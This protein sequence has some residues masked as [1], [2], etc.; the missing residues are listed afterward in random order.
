MVARHVGLKSEHSGDNGRIIGGVL[1][2]DLRL[3]LVGNS[4]AARWQEHARCWYTFQNARSAL[5][6]L[7]RSR[8]PKAVWLPAFICCELAA[9]VS[10]VVSHLRYFPVT[11][12]LS[13]D[14]KCLAANLATGDLVLAVDY[15]GRPPSADFR[16]FVGRRP[17]VLWVED[18]CQAL[19]PGSEPWGHWLLYS[20]RKLFG[21]PDG[22]I[23]VGVR[24]TVA[25]PTHID[26]DPYL[27]ELFWPVLWR[28]EDEDN[29]QAWYPAYRQAESRMSV[30]TRPMSRLSAAIL[31]SL[32]ADEIAARRR[33]NF[34]RLAESL[35]DLG[36]FADTK[37]SWVPLGF[38]IRVPERDRVVQHLAS[39][40][41]FCA[42]HWAELP[43]DPD[44]FRFEHQLA[45]QILTLPCDHRYGSAD[46]DRLVRAVR[47]ALA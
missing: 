5:A 14:V 10:S 26:D 25:P 40:R 7:I 38:P 15:F 39:A 32:D 23:L 4:V 8:S 35:S 42:R 24:D 37:L 12:D 1:P 11:D 41:M 30:T 44:R 2:L 13:P 34:A 18:R 27:V 47:A 16:A 21:V 31:S 20:P 29:N 46:M 22:G 43:S 45:R 33:Q 3:A 6:H 28:F 17:D 19:A 9:A 36:P